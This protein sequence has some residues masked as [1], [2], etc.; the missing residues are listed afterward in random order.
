[1]ANRRR[2]QHAR[3]RAPRPGSRTSPPN[4]ALLPT[5]PSPLDQL[6]AW[7]GAPGYYAIARALMRMIELPALGS[8]AEG[9]DI[10]SAADLAAF[11]GIVALEESHPVYVGPHQ[12]EV[13]P[14]WSASSDR[15][16]VA[17]A[18]RFAAEMPLPFDPLFLDFT[19][20]NGDPYWSVVGERAF[21]L[22][23]AVMFRA[24]N[25]PKGALV[26]AGQLAIVPCGVIMD[27]GEK[28][29]SPWA[30]APDILM[31]RQAA[32]G[33]VII[34]GDRQPAGG[35]LWLGESGYAGYMG[36]SVNERMVTLG[37]TVPVEIAADENVAFDVAARV[38]AGTGGNMQPLIG[39][40]RG[41]PVGRVALGE[42]APG[43]AGDVDAVIKESRLVLHLALDALRAMFLLD[44]T[45]V[46][47]VPASVSRQVRRAAERSEGRTRIAMTVRVKHRQR[48]ERPARAR[49]GKRTFSHSFERIGTY[50]HVTRGPQAKPEHMR[51]CPEDDELHRASGGRCRRYWV[52]SSVVDAGPGKPFIP[53]T[54]RVD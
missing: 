13:L 3:G 12:L 50:R 41:E 30:L 47:L 26:N 17:S 9:V 51:P 54:R 6:P 42:V 19:A 31:P 25:S 15:E 52:S 21:G 32:A 18:L 7:E 16:A 43:F 29:Q 46:E 1:M 49:A 33:L 45:N 38:I 10:I 22:F 23:G 28:R 39:V 27:D 5:N 20:E 53:K 44:S 37:V 24:T 36:P 40:M 4:A 8:N 34:G 11:Q 35:E 2:N 48:T 14:P